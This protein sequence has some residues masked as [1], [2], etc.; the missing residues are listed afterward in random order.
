MLQTFIIHHKSKHNKYVQTPY[1]AI[2][3]QVQNKKLLCNTFTMIS[4][5]TMIT[6]RKCIPILSKHN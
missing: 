5:I 4:I 6:Q 1:A 2:Q 3:F